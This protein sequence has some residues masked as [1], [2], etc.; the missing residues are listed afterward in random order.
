[1]AKKPILLDPADGLIIDDV[2]KWAIE[3]H[4]RVQAYIKI[5][6]PTRAKYI[7]TASVARW[8]QAISIYFQV[9]VAL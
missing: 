1:M 6:G 5:A 2:G 9:L 8:E 7:A 4:A 3:K